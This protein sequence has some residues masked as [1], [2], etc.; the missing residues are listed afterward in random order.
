MSLFVEVRS[1]LAERKSENEL[2]NE[3]LETRDRVRIATKG[4]RQFV[5]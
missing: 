3:N 5:E 2:S 4:R 1:D